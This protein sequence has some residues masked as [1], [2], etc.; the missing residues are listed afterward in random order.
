M[1]ILRRPVK[2]ARSSSVHM[3]PET[4]G[5]S[6][7]P[8]QPI[9]VQRSRSEVGKKVN[10][11]K[12][13]NKV[14]SPTSNPASAPPHLQRTAHPVIGRRKFQVGGQLKKELNP[15]QVDSAVQAWR[16]SP[17]WYER[18]SGRA[19]LTDS[20][21][22]M[23]LLGSAA[24]SAGKVSGFL[25]KYI[26]KKADQELGSLLAGKATNLVWSDAQPIGTA[27]LTTTEHAVPKIYWGKQG[28]DFLSGK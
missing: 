12:E 19:E 26:T 15:T 21:I 13:R 10:T 17:E 7:L 24:G 27:V 22:D 4:D 9:S 1:P 14:V 18:S 28:M 2:G 11:M 3:M 8:D 23:M 5:L 25:S 20:P 6:K 16:K